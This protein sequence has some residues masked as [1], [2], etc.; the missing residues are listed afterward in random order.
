MTAMPPT[1]GSEGLLSR[2]GLHRTEL[3]AWAMYDWANSAFV[4]TVQ[5]AVFPVYYQRVAAAGL[6]GPVATQR[7]TF[8]TALALTLVALLAPLLGAMAD[9]RGTRKRFLAAFFTL[10][11]VTTGTM[12]LVDHGDWVL[13]L[14]LFG[15]ASVGAQGSFVFYDSLLSHVARDPDEMDRVSTSGYAL[16]YLG[17]AILLALQLA[18]IREP[19]LFGLPEGT[20]PTRLAFLSVAVW[21]LAFAIPLFRHVS[22]P[23]R[24]LEADEAPTQRAF[25]VAIVRLR[26]TFGEI[27]RYRQAF[28]MLLAFLAYNDGIGTII[29][30]AGIYGAEI[31]IGT[32]ALIGSIL[33]SQIV[34]VPFAFLFGR[35]AGRFGP[36]P[37][38]LGG[39]VVYMGV[40]A[41]AYVL[42][43]AFEFLVLAIVVGMVQ[44]GCQALSRSLFA[45]LVPRHKSSEFFAFYSVVSKFAGIFG[46]LVFGLTIGLT[47]SSRQAILSVL[48]F[49]VAGALL[50]TRVDVEEGRRIAREATPAM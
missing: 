12:V 8:A 31:G 1:V 43:S 40:T 47:G 37:A 49:F 7:Y 42:D 35:L 25:R 5:T 38:I 45:S 34:G 9:F 10:G 22:E 14:V 17:S 50:L 3:R 33:V 28:L 48:F 30:M 4:L 24:R 11:F 18:W 16:G 15:L 41:Y 32:T 23:P 20:L 21:W 39:L 6:P 44:G 13:A 36:R 27:R 26:E 19:G 29:K 2:I 46:P